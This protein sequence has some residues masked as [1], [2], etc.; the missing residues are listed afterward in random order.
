MKEDY[1][2]DFGKYEG[3]KISEV[4]ASYLVW[5]YESLPNRSY[6]KRRRIY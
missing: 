6:A 3:K 4:P 1:E 5:C 2:I